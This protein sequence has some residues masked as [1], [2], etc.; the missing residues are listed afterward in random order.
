MKMLICSDGSPQAENA[1]Q[2]GGRI[3]SLCQAEVTI[4]GIPENPVDEEKIYNALKHGQ[5]F[6]RQQYRVT[7]EAVVRAGRPLVEIVQQTQGTPYDLVVIASGR[8][9]THGLFWMSRRTYR[10]IKA[11]EPPV[12]VAVGE[13]VALQR[14][15]VCSGGWKSASGAVDLVGEIAKRAGAAVTLFHVMAEPPAMYADLLRMEEDPDFLERSDS[16]LSKDLKREKELLEEA[17][18]NCR[19]RVA[20][21]LVVPAILKEVRQEDYDL[22]VIGSYP[23]PAGLQNYMLGNITREIVNRIDRPVLVVR[24]ARKPVGFLRS[25]LNLTDALARSKG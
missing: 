22:I 10:I 14:I 17:G 12:L 1:I 4:L 7:S 6:L 24:S 25:L 13:R 21:G 9:A 19:L 5:Q 3:A 8:K 20:H 11:V 23:S 18:A 2:F 16:E 15:L